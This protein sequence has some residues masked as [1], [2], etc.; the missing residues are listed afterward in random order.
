[1]LNIEVSHLLGSVYI[2]AGL[3][4]ILS[5]NIYLSP[6]SHKMVDNK[7]EISHI[8]SYKNIYI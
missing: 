1:M 8:K 5:L 7:S 4:H 2:Y 3:S 6:K